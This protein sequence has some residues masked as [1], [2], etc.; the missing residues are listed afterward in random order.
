M[1][2]GPHAGCPARACT[3]FTSTSRRQEERQVS[4]CTPWAG[5]LNL[6]MAHLTLEGVS[7][8]RPFDLGALLLS[9]LQRFGHDFNYER[10]A[11]SVRQVACLSRPP[12]CPTMASP[13]LDAHGQHI[14]THQGC[15]PAP[16]ACLSC[17]AG[18]P[19]SVRL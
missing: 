11:V 15:T 18:L 10:Q 19:L 7:A 8:A 2:C 6:V 9:F 17:Q 3:V 16:S 1:W 5:L 4:P 14:T 12:P 13:H